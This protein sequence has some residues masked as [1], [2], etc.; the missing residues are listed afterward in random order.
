[1]SD[2]T[3]GPPSE[4]SRLARA[5][6]ERRA[7][8]EARLRGQ[9]VP[10]Q[11][12][13]EPAPEPAAAPGPP[14]PAPPQ[15]EP[16]PVSSPEPPVSPEPAPP[17]PET[18]PPEPAPEP[19]PPPEPAPELPPEPDPMREPQTPVSLRRS[20]PADPEATGPVVP[21]RQRAADL[22][23]LLRSDSTDTATRIVLVPGRYVLG[24]GEDADVR[25]FGPTVSRHHARIDIDVGGASVQDLN[26]T[27]GTRVNG[28][29]A[30]GSLRLVAGDV[31]ALGQVTLD[32]L[33]AP[34]P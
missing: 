8:L 24:R 2:P 27:N 10:A 1:M 7:R 18:A 31:L 26:S 9:P 32:V 11:P 13:P 6:H 12:A 15:P 34:D 16:A 4:L 17:E 5:Q 33:Q 21:E 20:P 29:R 19:G 25:V 30:T 3:Q 14:E 28:D 22:T 23:L